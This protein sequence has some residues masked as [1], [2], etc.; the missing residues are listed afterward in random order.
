MC[1]LAVREHNLRRPTAERRLPAFGG[2]LLLAFGTLLV[3]LFDNKIVQAYQ[4]RSW[5]PFFI[6]L[7]VLG[8]VVKDGVSGLVSNLCPWDDN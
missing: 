5:L 4:F 7:I 3:S 2:I 1:G 6:V 8:Q